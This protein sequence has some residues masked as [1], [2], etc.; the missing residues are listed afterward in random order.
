MS[1][2]RISTPTAPINETPQNLTLLTAATPSPASLREAPSPAMRERGCQGEAL[3]SPSPASREREGPSPQGWEGEGL[4][5]L[6]SPQDSVDHTVGV[7]EDVAVPET[8][9]MPA[10][11]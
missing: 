5:S 2:V 10:V 1:R 4:S 8:D 3:E 11:T 6:E 7:G 9:Y